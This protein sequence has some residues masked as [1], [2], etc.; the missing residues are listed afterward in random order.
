MKAFLIARVST[1]EQKDALPAQTYRLI[2]YANRQGY[3]YELVEIRE[4]AY[5]GKRFWF[6]Q[7]VDRIKT[8][9]EGVIVVF[10]K[11]DRYTRDSSSEEVRTLN[12]L[13]RDGRVEIHF[14]SDNLFIHRDSPASDELRLGMGVVVAQYY[15]DAISD[16]VKRRFEQKLRDGEWIGMAPIGYKNVTL[17]NGKKWVEVDTFL[18]EVIRDSFK[19]Y[20]NGTISMKAIADRWRKVH[21]LSVSVSKIEW[22]LNNPF[23]YGAMRSK[24]KLYSHKYDAIISKDTFDKVAEIKKGYTIKPHR[25]GGLP[26]AYRGLIYCGDCGCKITFELKKKKYTLGHCTQSKFKH[27]FRYINEET[28]TDQFS[29]LFSKIEIPEDAYAFVSEG[30]RKSHQDKKKLHLE[31]LSHIEGEITKYRN[32]QDQ[33]YEDYLDKKISED[34]YMRKSNEYREKQKVYQ[35]KRENIEL[36]DDKYYATASHLLE[37]AKNANSLFKSADIEQKRNLLNIVLSNCTLTGDLLRWKLK[38]PFDSMVLCSETSS[39]LRRLDS[40]QWPF[41]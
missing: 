17:P 16:N 3:S 14:P 39:W 29:K 15:S 37:L 30:L 23:Y 13:R 12:S 27:P 6:A 31:T 20:S 24:G 22:I 7:L 35:F 19:L 38:E 34:V 5:S 2:D 25:W 28:I 9:S 1:D 32:R 8:H 26:F 18:A 4:S 21:G 36:I 33:V 41:D 11:I 10:D 40:N